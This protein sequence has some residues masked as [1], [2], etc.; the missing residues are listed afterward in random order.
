MSERASAA[1][2]AA[3]S[4]QRLGEDKTVA[5]LGG[6][7]VILWSVAAAEAAGVFDEIV[8]V[9]AP[10]SVAAV[11]DVVRRHLARI[12]VVPGGATRT[13]SSWAAL[14]ATNGDVLAIHDAARPFVTPSLFARSVEVARRD[15]A[16][17]AGSPLADTVRR[18]DE[19]GASLEEL[20]RE[21]LWQVQTPQAFRR[22]VLERAR[23]AAAERTFTDDGAAVVASGARIRMIA[24]ER[25]NLKITTSEDLAYA[26]ELVA[27]GIV[28]MSAPARGPTALA[29]PHRS[30][31]SAGRDTRTPFRTGLG[32]DIHRL[33]PDR[34]LV[35]GGV[36]IE[37]PTGLLGHSD[38]DVLCHAVMD[39]LLGAA[40]LGDLG[41]HFPSDD[42]G[43]A[44]ASS[45]GLLRRVA[46]LLRDAGFVVASVDATVIAQAPRLAPYVAAMRGAIAEAMGVDPARVSVK[47]TTNDGLGDV[48]AG[49]AIAAMATALVER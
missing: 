19:V 37:H 17:V 33:A 13:A 38:G 28:A 44:G 36:A 24:G 25:R 23:A 4:S 30:A 10:Q 15:G 48:G 39:A 45:L 11:E 42:P 26:R 35:L 20:E 40:G 46:A 22:E 16:A 6:R 2:L 3:G 8:V 29:A 21:G 27:K 18:A 9:A 12:R 49:Q 41:T 5:D 32:Y 47:A 31:P 43:F 34:R 14:A 7:P 1:I